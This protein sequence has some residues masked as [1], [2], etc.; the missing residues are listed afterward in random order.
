MFSCHCRKAKHKP[1]TINQLR[2]HGLCVRNEDLLQLQEVEWNASIPSASL[3]VSVPQAAFSSRASAIVSKETSA[4]R[5]P[6]SRTVV[7]FPSFVQCIDNC[8]QAYS[9]SI[10][11]PHTAHALSR[12]CPIS[13]TP[14]VSLREYWLP[15][16]PGASHYR[17][18]LLFRSS[19]PWCGIGEEN[20]KNVLYLKWCRGFEMSLYIRMLSCL[21]PCI[22]Y[23]SAYDSESVFKS[24]VLTYQD[25][26]LLS[27]L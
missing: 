18:F 13:H 25:L 16:T 14:C 21:L 8:L 12:A 6:S 5:A 11:A 2:A 24:S 15:H 27:V 19:W 17:H 4:S 26:S 22:R 1:L 7:H 9:S 20:K 23:V 10:C 3:H